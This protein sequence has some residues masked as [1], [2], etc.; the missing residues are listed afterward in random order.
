MVYASIAMMQSRL[1]YKC[2]AVWPRFALYKWSSVVSSAIP[3]KQ[4]YRSVCGE[5]IL[6]IPLK[7]LFCAFMPETVVDLPYN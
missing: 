6:N 2:L 3:E 1:T 5:T 4:L 7:T